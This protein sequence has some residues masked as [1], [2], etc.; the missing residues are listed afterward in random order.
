MA[1]GRWVMAVQAGVAAAVVPG[2]VSAHHTPTDA[3]RYSARE[4]SP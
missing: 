3:C 2:L 1:E 4:W